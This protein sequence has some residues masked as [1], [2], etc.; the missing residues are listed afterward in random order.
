MKV[1]FLSMWYPNGQ[2]P[3]SGTFVHEQARALRQIGVELRVMQPLP[4]APF[5]VTLFKPSYRDWAAV[6][7]EESY[8]GHPVYHPRYLTLPRHALFEWVGDWMYGAIRNRIRALHGQWPFDI[9]HAH[10]TYPCGYAA[11]RCRDELLPQVKVVHTIHGTCVRDAPSYN[12]ACFDKV[13][14]GLEGADCTVFVSSEGRGLGLEYT[15]GRIAGRSQY[16]TNG[17]DAEKFSLNESERMEVQALK[18][19]HSAS[20]NLLFVGNLSA[21]KGIKDLLDAVRSRVQGGATRG[22]RP[23]SLGRRFLQDR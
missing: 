22:R 19:M 6:S 23:F 16:I 15:G 12:R 2:N 17:V 1:L 21:A 4:M 10:A 18:A 9:I 7:S 13:R 20:W 3:V 11:N 14:T 8:A 5:P